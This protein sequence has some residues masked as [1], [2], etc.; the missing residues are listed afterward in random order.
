[1]KEEETGTNSTALSWFRSALSEQK[2]VIYS[3]TSQ[4]E[5]RQLGT[6]SLTISHKEKSEW[7]FKMSSFSSTSSLSLIKQKEILTVLAGF[8]IFS[9]CLVE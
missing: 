3:Y 8:I 7:S 6:V 5:R 4:L 2:H 1:M 9:M